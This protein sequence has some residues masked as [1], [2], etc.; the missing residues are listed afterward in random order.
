MPPVA[1]ERDY[2]PEG[3]D[4]LSMANRPGNA[5]S[6]VATLNIEALQPPF[7]PRAY[8]IGLCRFSQRQEVQGMTTSHGIALTGF[9]QASCGIFSDHV[10]HVKAR[11]D[12]IVFD[13][14]QTLIH[15]CADAFER[16]AH[17][18]SRT[19]DAAHILKAPATGEDG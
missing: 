17:F 1:P 7:I 14:D 10:Q 9:P 12:A 3:Q 19:A 4:R 13:H 2:I 18:S 15:Q 16:T 8:Q 11:R 6:Q 5:S